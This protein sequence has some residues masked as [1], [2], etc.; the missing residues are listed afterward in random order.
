MVRLRQGEFTDE[1]VFSDD[2]VGMARTLE[3]AGAAWLHVVDLDGARAGRP[4]QLLVVAELVRAVRCRVQLGG[5]LSSDEVIASAFELGVSRVV[6]G[7]ALFG[8]ADPPSLVSEEPDRC[9]AALDVR[10]GRVRTAGW[11]EGDFPVTD[12]VA[13]CVDLGLSRALVT[14]ISRDGMM[15]GPNLALA[16]SVVRGGVPEVLVSGGVASAEDLLAA[17]DAGFAGAIVGMALYSGA[18]DLKDRPPVASRLLNS[19]SRWLTSRLADG[20]PREQP[21]LPRTGWGSCS[22]RWVCALMSSCPSCGHDVP[23][24]LKECPRCEGSTQA[25]SSR[26]KIG[27]F[28]VKR[29][30][31]PEAWVPSTWPRT[32]PWD[33]ASPSR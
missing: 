25:F 13:R 32:R 22:I 5:G 12:A 17:R 9:V 21:N 23:R 16:D 26:V 30:L 11:R 3:D 19:P 1:T 28:R 7:S 18:V 31:G 24:D 10:D 4:A 27:G 29:C 33:G 2:P 20:A 8:A 6:L 14:D 15:S